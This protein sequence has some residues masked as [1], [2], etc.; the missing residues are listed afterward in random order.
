MIGSSIARGQAPAAKGDPELKTMEQ[1]AAYA[2]GL[3]MGKR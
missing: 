2:I 1:K 3:N